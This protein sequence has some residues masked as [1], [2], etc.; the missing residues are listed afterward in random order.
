MFNGFSGAKLE[1]ISN[2]VLRKSGGE[3]LVK[4]AKKQQLYENNGII[5]APKVLE[6]G[7][8]YFDMQYIRN[9]GVMGFLNRAS[10]KHLD[11][12]LCHILAFFI[13]NYSQ[14]PYTE[15]K[16]EIAAKCSSLGVDLPIPNS[17]RLPSGY[18]HG[19]LTLGNI[20]YSSKLTTFYLVDFLDSYI[21]SPVLDLVKFRQD[22]HL[23][24]CLF[25]YNDMNNLRAKIA[26]DYLDKKLLE[27]YDIPHYNLLQKINLYR[28]IPYC[29]TKLEKDYVFSLISELC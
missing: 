22:T 17:I 21:D 6:I 8:D 1:I 24:W 26:L 16:N 13:T 15:F 3:R 7:P 4:Q 25:I 29:R 28:I 19:D 5:K 20:L 27:M 10:K 23:K 11:I 9:I 2:G 18:N 14:I 12:L